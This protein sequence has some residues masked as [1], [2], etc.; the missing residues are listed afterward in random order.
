MREACLIFA[1]NAACDIINIAYNLINPDPNVTCCLINPAPI[2]LSVTW[3]ILF[4]I[5]FLTW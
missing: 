3:L 4:L 2:I 1:P 5:L